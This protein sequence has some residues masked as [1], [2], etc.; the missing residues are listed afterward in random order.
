MV[1]DGIG[2]GKG[3]G[4]HGGSGDRVGGATESTKHREVV[5]GARR[6]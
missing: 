3:E 5:N 2:G 4:Q 6:I 1:N